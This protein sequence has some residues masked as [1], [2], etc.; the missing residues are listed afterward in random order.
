MTKVQ[1]V[2]TVQ[3]IL[4]KKISVSSASVKSHTDTVICSGLLQNKLKN[5]CLFFWSVFALEKWL[6][7][8]SLFLQLCNFY[9][10]IT[11]LTFLKGSLADIFGPKSTKYSKLNSCRNSRKSQKPNQLK[12][13]S[14][15][16]TNLFL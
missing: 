12:V 2:Y 14:I 5:S 16:L 11:F 9:I 6:S 15:Y 1:L 13:L 7:V 3:H 4:L 8:E 10:C